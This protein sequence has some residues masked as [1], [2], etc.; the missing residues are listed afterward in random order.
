MDTI[1]RRALNFDFAKFCSV[2]MSTNNVYVCLVCG[3][4]FQGKGP[5]T[6]AYTHAVSC[7]HYVFMALRND[8]PGAEGRVFVLPDN[9]EVVDRS[10]DDIRHELNPSF[11]REQVQDLD[12]SA[13][14]ANAPPRASSSGLATGS[15]GCRGAIRSTEAR[16]LTA[17]IPTTSA[18]VD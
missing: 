3:S 14:W 2:T 8:K 12:K 1:D 6:P 16:E 5:S 15:T 9:Y 18:K 17:T 10:L 11:T 4:L 13:A 7:G